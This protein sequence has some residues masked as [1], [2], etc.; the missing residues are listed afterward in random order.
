MTV[1]SGSI[2]TPRLPHEITDSAVRPSAEPRRARRCALH[3]FLHTSSRQGPHTPKRA[4]SCHADI[5]N[6]A[7]GHNPRHCNQKASLINPAATLT[8]DRPVHRIHRIY[9]LPFH[10]RGQNQTSARGRSEQPPKQRSWVFETGLRHHHH[11]E[12]DLWLRSRLTWCSGVSPPELSAEQRVVGHLRTIRGGPPSFM[13]P[14]V[15]SQ[16]RRWHCLGTKPKTQYPSSARLGL[17]VKSTCGSSGA[18]GGERAN[19]PCRSSSGSDHQGGEAVRPPP[20]SP[21]RV[22][23][24]AS[25]MPSYVYSSDTHPGTANHTHRG[26]RRR[27]AVTR[28]RHARLPP[29]R[30]PISDA[31]ASACKIRK[32]P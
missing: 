29:G 20:W 11:C 17:A 16:L 14:C 23:F 12:R 31:A 32:P 15:T 4:T 7:S 3:R 28:G 10:T 21:P 2:A 1:P 6:S 13:A 18:W 27:R 8:S 26:P 30:K 25:P 9:T 24:T 22:R 19:P 5:I